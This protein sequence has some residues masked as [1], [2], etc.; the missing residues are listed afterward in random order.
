MGKEKVVCTYIGILHGLKN[1]RNSAICD[2]LV[3]L[4]VIMLSKISSHRK[5]NIACD[6]TSYDIS[7]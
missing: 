5:T 6:S 1:D 3:N 4:E 2:N 7:K